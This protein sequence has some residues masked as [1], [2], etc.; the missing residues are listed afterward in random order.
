M[1]DPTLKTI[2]A[3]QIPGLFGESQW[4]TRFLLYQHFAGNVDLDNT[5]DDRME[6]GTRLQAPVMD[7][8]QE[9]LGLEILNNGSDLYFRHPKFEKPSYQIGCTPD[10]YVWSPDRGL[11]FVEIKCVD[12]RIY[13]ESW[14]PK[15]APKHVEIQH[16]VQ[17]MVPLGS[18]KDLKE[19]NFLPMMDEPMC[20]FIRAHA[21]QEPQWGMIVAFVGGNSIKIIERKAKK[22]IQKAIRGEVKSFF[23]SLKNGRV[24]PVTGLSCELPALNELYPETEDTTLHDEDFGD[25][26]AGLLLEMRAFDYWS[27]QASLAKGEKEKARIQLI[28]R[29]GNSERIRI[30]GAVATMKKTQLEGTTKSMAP[31]VNALV[32]AVAEREKELKFKQALNL[33]AEFK[34]VLRKPS[35]QN[36]INVTILADEI[37]DPFV[38]D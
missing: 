12:G 7:H 18:M 19:D 36:R 26:I 15:T 28:Q 31:W 30:S 6:W 1:P 5:A 37:A 16:Q 4:T 21:G 9:N 33:A 25:D 38:I 2:S 10:G 8:L 32:R 3:S 17:L 35:I 20:E 11:G 24:P 27:R 23:E 14:T 22:T 13:R 29:F 34:V